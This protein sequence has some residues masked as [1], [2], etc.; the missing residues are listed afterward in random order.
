MI[1]FIGG[2]L[3]LP[4]I[5]FGIVKKEDQKRVNSFNRSKLI[6]RKHFDPSNKWQKLIQQ[7]TLI[8]KK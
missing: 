2:F 1:Y 8:I 7:K 3:L 5:I 6:G 4:V